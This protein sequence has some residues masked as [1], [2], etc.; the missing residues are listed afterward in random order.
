MIEADQNVAVEEM[1]EKMEVEFLK[2]FEEDKLLFLHKAL[3]NQSLVVK[4]PDNCSYNVKISDLAENKNTFTN[5]FVICGEQTK[6]TIIFDRSSQDAY[7]KSSIVKII[8]KKGSKVKI[9]H[10]QD[11][12]EKTINFEKEI[13]IV[14]K[15][16]HVQVV[17]VCAGSFFTKR[18]VHTELK[19]EGATI[20]V[21]GINF[22]RQEQTFDLHYSM[23][24]SA[25]N[26]SS[27]MLM[28]GVLDGKAKCVLRGL[29]KIAKNCS[30]C[31]GY[32][33][34]DTL[35]LS[36]SAESDL[37]PKLEIDNDDVKCSHGSTV[38]HLDS[39]KMFYL[40]SRGLGEEEAKRKIV[41]GF[42]SEV[43]DGVVEIK[44]QVMENILT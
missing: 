3:C 17:D 6:S 27:N 18:D 25:K 28:K 34:E 35:L 38:T 7:Y 19:E 20:Q 21:S 32:Q 36:E 33:K 29:V 5:I 9:I 42:V 15:D 24:H 10:L 1:N 43:L 40:M 26:T 39:E 41:E 14:E 37:L 4:I 13:V 16:S 23:I 44:E 31:R 2:G 8:A 22:G 11:A 12:G 30:G